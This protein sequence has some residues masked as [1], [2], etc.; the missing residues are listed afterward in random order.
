MTGDPILAASQRTLGRAL[1]STAARRGPAIAL[2]DGDRVYSFSELNS[3][4]NRLA[5]ALRALGLGRGDRI[6][7][8]AENRAEYAF[9]FYAAA[10]LGVAV[11]PLNWRLPA[12]ELGPVIAG[13]AR[14]WRSCPR[15]TGSCSPPRPAH[16]RLTSAW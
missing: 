7:I 6:A 9:V 5:N 10:K 3:T 8:L 16:P 4:S 15:A 1:A 12:A 11:S 13:S 2:E 14:D